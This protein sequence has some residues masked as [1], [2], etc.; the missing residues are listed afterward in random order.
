MGGLWLLPALTNTPPEKMPSDFMSGVPLIITWTLVVGLLTVALLGLGRAYRVGGRVL[1]TLCVVGLWGFSLFMLA[2][3]M[4]HILSVRSLGR[5][6]LAP[7][8]VVLAGLT[9]YVALPLRSGTRVPDRS[10][11]GGRDGGP[12]AKRLLRTAAWVA[13]CLIVAAALFHYVY[14][15]W[16]LQ[17]GATEEEA[18]RVLAGDEICEDANF[19][20][21][22]AI[23]IDASP[24]DVWPWIVQIGYKR[25]GFYSYDSIDNAGIPSA[26]RILPEFQ[27]VKVGD[28]IPLDRSGAVLVRTLEPNRLLVLASEPAFLTWTWD[29]RPE[30]LGQTRVVTRVRARLDDPQ[31]KFVWDTF[32]FFMMR[33]CLL[34]IKRRAEGKYEVRSAKYEVPG[35]SH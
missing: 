11:A 4:F 23:T 15:P 20:P 5:H 28:R 17:W 3:A 1:Q 26:E 21:T 9:A 25:A 29:L 18:T 2:G 7:M 13:G 33:K 6:A 8:S 30:V 12:L 24:E 35:E 22:R 14:L 31:A 34:G 16:N 27:D 32:E 19:S 10:A